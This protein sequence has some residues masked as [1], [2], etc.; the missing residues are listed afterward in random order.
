MHRKESV[1]GMRTSMASFTNDMYKN[2]PMLSAI[3]K[4][5]PTVEP[6]TPTGNLPEDQDDFPKM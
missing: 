5:P 3:A 6:P 4:P 2:N 1:N